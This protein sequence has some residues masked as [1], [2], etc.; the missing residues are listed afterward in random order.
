MDN[1]ICA[2][3]MLY[4]VTIS[5]IKG[6][7]FKVDFQKKKLIVFIG[8]FCLKLLKVRVLILYGLKI[9]YNRKDIY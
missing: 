2:H 9:H 7:L 4:P 5:K 1:I 3:K 8:T 6:V